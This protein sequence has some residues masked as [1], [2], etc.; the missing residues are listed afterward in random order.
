MGEFCRFIGP[1]PYRI[2]L[3]AVLPILPLILLI[4]RLI[5]AAPDYFTDLADLYRIFPKAFKK[6][7]P[8]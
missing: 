3:V 2:L 5:Q 8:L 4:G 1:I 6:G 7:E